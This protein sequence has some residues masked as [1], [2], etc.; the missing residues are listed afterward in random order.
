MITPKEIQTKQFSKVMR[1]YKDEEVDMFL[2]L[3]I[4]P[5]GDPY[6]DDSVFHEISDLGVCQCASK[7]NGMHQTDQKAKGQ[8][9]RKKYQRLFQ[10]F[11]VFH[12]H[13]SVPHPSQNTRNRGP[14]TEKSDRKPHCIAVSC[15]PF[16]S[17]GQLN[18]SYFRADPQIRQ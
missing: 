7:S 16:I 1:G 8:K 12:T 6:L 14:R 9:T 11:S 13:F 15:H 18:C 2:D 10:T 17:Y 3:I 4:R 5:E